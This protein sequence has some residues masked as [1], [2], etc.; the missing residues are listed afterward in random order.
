MQDQERE[1]KASKKSKRKQ[2]FRDPQDRVF[3]M[4]E[5]LVP[6]LLSPKP[7]CRGPSPPPPVS[8]GLTSHDE[9]WTK[10][11]AETAGGVGEAASRPSTRD[12]AL[13]P[14]YR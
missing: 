14:H 4:F 13:K 8:P 7:I 1:K 6:Q 2:L 3:P 5:F 11:P 12:I 9:E 10:D